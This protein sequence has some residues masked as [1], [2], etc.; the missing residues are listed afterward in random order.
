[1][2]AQLLKLMGLK[3]MRVKPTDAPTGA[4]KKPGFSSLGVDDAAPRD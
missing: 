1:M 3:A 4:P 2:G